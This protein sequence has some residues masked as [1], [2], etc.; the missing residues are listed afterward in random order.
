M[1]HMVAAKFGRF[2]SSNPVVTLHC[3]PSLTESILSC[4]SPLAER[5]G[6][7]AIYS[8]VNVPSQPERSR[9]RLECVWVPRNGLKAI[10]IA[11][12]PI[13]RDP[14]ALKRLH[15]QC[16]LCINLIDLLCAYVDL[17]CRKVK[18]PNAGKGFYRSEIA[19]LRRA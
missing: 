2:L 13:S 4:P 10:L 18:P 1:V 11:I 5:A 12:P 17:H 19:P 8:V 14:N 3:R 6:R 7:Q 15:R 9:L 16:L